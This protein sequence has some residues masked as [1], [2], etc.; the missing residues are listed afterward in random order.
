MPSFTQTERGPT[1]YHP[2]N[3][4]FFLLSRATPAAYGGSQ[5]RSRIGAT[6]AGYTTATAMP[7]LSCAYNLH[8]SSWQL[9]ILN[10]LS[11]LRNRAASWILVRFLN[12]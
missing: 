2:K 6:A 10:P 3:F 5:A 9:Q 1:V 11:E 8:H 4:F 12:C 7:D